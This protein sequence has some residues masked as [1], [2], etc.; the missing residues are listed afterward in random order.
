MSP[1]ADTENAATTV[2]ESPH[3]VFQYDRFMQFVH[4]ITLLFLT[5][6][7][8]T[9]WLIR[10]ADTREQVIGLLELHRSLGLTILCITAC[11]LMWRLVARIP[12]LPQDLPRLQ[13]FAARAN[14]YALY[15]LLFLQPSLGFLHSNAAGKPVVVYFLGAIPSLLATDKILARQIFMAHDVVAKLLLGLI[16]LHVIAAL[17]HHFIRS[18]DVLRTMLPRRRLPSSAATCDTLSDGHS[19]AM[20]QLQARHSWSLAKRPT[21]KDAGFE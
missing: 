2:A 14:E 10:Y 20:V 17:F 18:D 21:R 15:T 6:T 1:A 11:R 9:A 16:T 13:R 8:A 7:F 12:P 4:W 19:D 3:S 5:A